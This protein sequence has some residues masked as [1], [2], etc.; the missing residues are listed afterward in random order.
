MGDNRPRSRREWLGVCAGTAGI[1][2]LAGCA[3]DDETDDESET[4]DDG[5]LNLGDDSSGDWPMFGAD[6]QNTGYQPDGDGPV[7]D[8]EVRWRL[9][10]DGRF[11]SSPAVVDGTVYAGC[12]D[13]YLYAVDSQTGSTEWAVELNMRATPSPTVIDGIV[14]ASSHGV[15]DKMHALEADSGEQL[16][17]EEL[18][19]STHSPAPYGSEIYT[20]HSGRLIGLDRDS[21]SSSVLFEGYRQTP[22]AP[23]IKDGVLFGGG[24]RSIVAHD[25]TRD[26]IKWEF[27]NKNGEYM[28]TGSPAVQGESL[29]VGAGDGKLY[30]INADDGVE[31]WS[32][33]TEGPLSFGPA[34]SENTVFISGFDG[35]LYAINTETGQKRW[36]IDFDTILHGKPAVTSEMVY[37][38]DGKSL[39]GI[40]K[41]NGEKQWSFTPNEDKTIGGSTAV[42]DGVLYLPS[43]DHHL[44]ALEEA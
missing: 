9:E 43:R 1:T 31:E 16:W 22:D 11:V 8:V 10:G 6:L 24:R 36:Y 14:Y 32:F 23:A 26:E 34:V 42:A 41:N 28:S 30:S 33:E 37:L 21:G 3:S 38:I 4:T 35:H 29:Y 40:S 15:P 20:Y 7:D 2:M 18:D 5:L 17:E 25:L 39:S 19:N 12:R 44:Y 13:G 27:E